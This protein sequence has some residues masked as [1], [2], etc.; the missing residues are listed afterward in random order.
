MAYGGMVMLAGVLPIVAAFLL[1][2]V[3]QV[4]RRNGPR[5]VL[6]ALGMTAAVAVVGYIMYQYGI[7]SPAVTPANRASVTHVGS[8]FLT[9][10]IPLALL[11]FLIRTGKLLLSKRRIRG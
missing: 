3:V 5:Y 10:S 11:A 6:L 9:F 8:M 1:D 7:S 4:L 2:G